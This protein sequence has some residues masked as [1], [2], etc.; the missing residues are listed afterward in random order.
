MAGGFLNES[1][2]PNFFVRK[3]TNYIMILMVTMAG[4]KLEQL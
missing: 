1:I 2:K 3:C 4:M